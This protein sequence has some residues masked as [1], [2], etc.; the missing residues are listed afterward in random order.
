MVLR[1]YE[2][3]RDVLDDLIA[4]G[5]EGVVKAAKTWQPNSSPWTAW[6]TLKARGAI[7]DFL[8]QG[9]GTPKGITQVSLQALMWEEDP[10]SANGEATRPR[11]DIP[12]PPDE[13]DTGEAADRAREV[14]EALARLKPEQ[15]EAIHLFYWQD[16]PA[17][18]VARKLGTTETTA[19]QWAHRGREKLRRDPRLLALREAA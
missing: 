3:N 7:L 5:M 14:H 18:E 19:Y 4:A 10:G 17:R 8:R 12:A 2:F 16:L 9:F 13:Y 15:R 11:F 1:E 6:A